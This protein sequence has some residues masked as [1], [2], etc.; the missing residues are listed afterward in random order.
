[1][2]THGQGQLHCG[3]PRVARKLLHQEMILNLLM[4]VCLPCFPEGEAFVCSC[5]ATLGPGVG[6]SFTWLPVVASCALLTSRPL[7]FSAPSLLPSPNKAE[8][9]G[10]V[11]QT[12]S[13]LGCRWIN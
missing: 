9:Q 7:F 2:S 5:A 3:C 1:M 13:S 6:Y 4:Q 8:V 11:C 12:A 10:H